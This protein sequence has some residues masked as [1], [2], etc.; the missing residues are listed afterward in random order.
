MY[1]AFIGMCLTFMLESLV[2]QPVSSTGNKERDIVCSGVCVAP[3][4]FEGTHISDKIANALSFLKKCEGGTILLKNTP[5]Y[6]I[7]EAIL[8]PSNI[9]M[10]IDGCKI[11]LED[12]VFDNMI[13][14]DNFIIDENAPNGYV[15]KLLP[16]ENISVIGMNGAIIEGADNV[17]EAPNPKTGKVEK[18]LG[19]YWGWRNFS[20]LF[21][22]VKNFE[23]SGFTLQKTHSWGVVTTNGC[24]NGKIHAIQFYTNVKN[25]DG[26]DIVQGCSHILVENISGTTSDDMIAIAVFDETRWTNS[27]YVYPLLPVRYSDY[28]YGD[29][30]HDI[31]CRNVEADGLFHVLI[32]LP[33]T[34]KIYNI[35]CSNISDVPGGTKKKIVKIYG[36]GPYGKE[37]KPG[38]MYNIYMNNLYSYNAGIVL[39]FLGEVYSSH[40]N[41]IVQNKPSGVCIRA[42]VQ[43]VNTKI[44]N[45]VNSK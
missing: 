41:R 23:I 10:I 4:D 24:Q 31:T 28:S 30:V 38:N 22:N 34:P 13:R 6:V 37:F 26:I 8:L 17:Y 44:T 39:E 16:A 29:D 11:K 15:K 14:S 36:N 1:K 18:W 40:F 43:N 2:A 9:K 5:I 3:E 25:G 7:R 45:I 12:G 21:S 42:E 33:A 35:Y 32:L 19:D 27:K 20:I